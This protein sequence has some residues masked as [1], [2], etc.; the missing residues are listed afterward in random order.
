LI[1]NNSPLNIKTLSP[2]DSRWKPFLE[3]FSKNEIIDLLYEEKLKSERNAE[4]ILLKEK[5]RLLE[6]IIVQAQSKLN[7]IRLT[8]A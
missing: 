7:L 2:N 1:L 5:I 3:K 8:N 6:Q 4:I